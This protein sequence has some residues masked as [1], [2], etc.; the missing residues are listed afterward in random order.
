MQM[1]DREYVE[2]T[3]PAIYIGH[4][5][6]RRKNGSTGATR[7]WH[8]EYTLNSRQ[9]SKSLG[10]PIKASARRLPPSNPPLRQPG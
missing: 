9:Q 5:V 2:G 8:A 4:R 10:T 6:L 1:K 3:E 7:L